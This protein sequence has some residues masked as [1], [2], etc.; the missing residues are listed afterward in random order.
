MKMLSIVVGDFF[1]T[2]VGLLTTGIIPCLNKRSKNSP[3]KNCFLF[4]RE[5]LLNILLT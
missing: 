4:P 2:L 5:V 1:V 3:A